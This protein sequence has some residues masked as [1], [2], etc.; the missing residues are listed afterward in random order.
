MR[1][2][3]CKRFEVIIWN[4]IKVAKI[5]DLLNLVHV[6]K[7]TKAMIFNTKLT[8]KVMLAFSIVHTRMK[9]VVYDSTQKNIIWRS[10]SMYTVSIRPRFLEN[11]LT[12]HSLCELHITLIDFD[13]SVFLLSSTNH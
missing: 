9:T 13:D 5:F 2:D 4:I 10:K 3:Q 11:I 1:Y 6:L 12:V 8:Q 7:L